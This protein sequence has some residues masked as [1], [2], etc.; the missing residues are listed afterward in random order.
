MTNEVLKVK[1]E[2]T[3]ICSVNVIIILE[4]IKMLWFDKPNQ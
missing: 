2:V 1:V 3:N 4:I